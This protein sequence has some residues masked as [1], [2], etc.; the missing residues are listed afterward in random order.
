MLATHLVSDTLNNLQLWKVQ[1]VDAKIAK[2]IELEIKIVNM[3]V[4]LSRILAF[5]GGFI[6]TMP[7]KNFKKMCFPLSIIEYYLPSWKNE[8]SVLYMSSYV[9]VSM[10]TVGSCNQVVYTTCHFR[11]Q[12]YLVLSA[13]KKLLSVK[14]KNEKDIYD[15]VRAK[16][17]QQDVKTKMIFI[18]KRTF[19]IFE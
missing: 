17:F 9:I 7:T 5:T 15:L 14:I 12:A 1:N 16:E 8:L 3:Y 2:R 18:I 10:A 4:I 6:M 11:I 19:R 13:M